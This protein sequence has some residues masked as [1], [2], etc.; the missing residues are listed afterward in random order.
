MTGLL[1]VLPGGDVED[2]RVGFLTLD[3]LLLCCL[4]SPDALEQGRDTHQ[5]PSRRNALALHDMRTAVLLLFHAFGADLTPSKR[6]SCPLGTV[7]QPPA[8]P[9]AYRPYPS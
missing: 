1:K 5:S 4:Y 7:Q 3:V 2:Q 8:P 6:P 9:Q